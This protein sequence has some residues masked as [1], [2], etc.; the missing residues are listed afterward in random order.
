MYDLLR[1]IPVLIEGLPL[2]RPLIISCD[3]RGGL[4]PNETKKFP[5]NHALR[6]AYSD[7]KTLII[8]QRKTS[9]L[10][11]LSKSDFE[12]LASFRRAL[13]HFLR[14]SEE[15]SRAVGLTPQQ[16][17][18]LL[19]IKGQPGQDFANLRQI[20]DFL[21]LKHQTVVGLVDR[22]EAA[23]LVERKPSTVDRRRVEVYLT[24][25]GEALLSKLSIRNLDELKAMRKFLKPS[26]LE[27]NS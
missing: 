26:F 8:M 5:W 23:G 3:V 15:G 19:G 1:C 27:G 14:F 22:C 18:L 24:P 21:Q 6:G 4:A 12:A 2:K 10:T 9:Q 25:H 20:A 11:E 16:H 7:I 13:R 17:Q